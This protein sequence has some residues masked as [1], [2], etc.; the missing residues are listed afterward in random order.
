ML[1]AMPRRAITKLFLTVHSLYQS[2]NTKP[3]VCL[4]EKRGSLQQGS[5]IMSVFRSN[6]LLTAVPVQKNEG[7]QGSLRRWNP[8]KGIPPSS[9]L[10]TLSPKL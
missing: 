2:S 6:S 4:A 7:R 1:D 3:N 5:A 8:S 10:A 9:I